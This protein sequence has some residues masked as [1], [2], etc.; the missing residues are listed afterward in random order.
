M[1]FNVP[2]FVDVEDKIAGP[3]TARQIF[4]MIGMGAVLMVL[5][6]L[7][8]TQ[9]FFVIAVPVVCIFMAFAFYRPYGQPLITLVGNAIL[10]LFRPKF[11]VW[12]R[13]TRVIERETS[14]IIAQTPVPS[15]MITTDEVNRLAKIV[16]QQR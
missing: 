1:L 9:L 16:D 2:Q 3:L 11:Y 10:F 4:W 8:D 5:W 12:S 6:G 7:F 14:N 15:K 13:P